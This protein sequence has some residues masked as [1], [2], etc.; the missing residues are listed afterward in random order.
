LEEGKMLRLFANTTPARAANSLGI[1]FGLHQ[2]IQFREATKKAGGTVKNNSGSP[3]QRLGLKKWG[4]QPVVPGNI[5]VRQRGRHFWEG[6]NVGVGKD[7]TL[8]SL[9]EGRVWF[10]KLR[11]ANGKMKTIVHVD[12]THLSSKCLQYEWMG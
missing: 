4:A 6:E 12:P 11:R 3:G 10:E 5:I 9:V 1:N 7:Y 8:Y 2:T